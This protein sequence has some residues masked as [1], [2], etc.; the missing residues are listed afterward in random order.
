MRGGDT[1]R[2]LI[3]EENLEQQRRRSDEITDEI[4]S[5]KQRQTKIPPT[6]EQCNRLANDDGDD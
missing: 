1:N 4:W 6:N 5:W 2:R 3:E